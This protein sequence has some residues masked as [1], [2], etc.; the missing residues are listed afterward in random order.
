MGKIEKLKNGLRVCRVNVF[1][2]N[3]LN[4]IAVKYN[5][6]PGFLGEGRL[7]A[8]SWFESPVLVPHGQMSI[9]Q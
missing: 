9:Y 3:H 1:D 8:Q 6:F 2:L 5:G 4:R 7:Y